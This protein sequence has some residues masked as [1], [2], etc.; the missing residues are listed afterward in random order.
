[1]QIKVLS[2]S[3]SPEYRALMLHAYEHA[4][5]A[6]TST[7]EERAL[8]SDAW[9]VKR[10]A[11]STGLTVSL[12]AFDEQVMIGTVALEFSEK[13]KIRHKSLLIGMYVLEA[14]RRRSIAK[15]L[16]LAAIEQCKARGGISVLQLEVTQGNAPAESLYQSFGFERFGLEP[17]AVLTP[18]GFR[19]KVHMWLS[20]AAAK[21]EA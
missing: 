5:D 10:V 1:M 13:P 3:D 12:G 7:P 8:E 6:F 17:L 16:L 11:D 18:V 19:S 20:L 14:C 2:A 15:A 4:A 9:W 21:N